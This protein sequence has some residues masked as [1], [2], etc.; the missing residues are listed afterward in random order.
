MSKNFFNNYHRVSKLFQPLNIPHKNASITKTEISKSY[1]V[2]IMTIII[3]YKQCFLLLFLNIF[4]NLFLS[5]FSK[6]DKL[7]SYINENFST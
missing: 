6:F 5:I 7:F 3:T 4:L 1:K 2:S